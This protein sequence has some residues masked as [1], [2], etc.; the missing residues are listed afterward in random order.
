MND[1]IQKIAEEFRLKKYQ[2]E[3]TL[4]LLKEE[5]T[6]PF[7]AHYRQDRTGGLDDGRIRAIRERWRYLDELEQRRALAINTIAAAGQMTPELKTK[8]ENTPSRVELEDVFMP[9]RSRRRV[10][11][12]AARQKGLD[13]LADLIWQQVKPETIT[14]GGL[15]AGASSQGSTAGNVKPEEGNPKPETPAPSTEPASQKPELVSQSVE[16]AAQQPEAATRSTE[17]DAQKPEPAVQSADAAAQQPEAATQSTESAAQNPEPAAQSADAAAQQPEAATQSTES[18]AQNPEPAAQSTGAAAQQ[19]EAATQSTPDDAPKKEGP[20]QEQIE[21]RKSKIEN[22]LPPCSPAEALV[23][24]FINAEK[25][26]KDMA[27]AL[28][29]ARDIVA[30]RIAENAAFRKIA[31]ELL[32]R[33]GKFATK[34]RDGVDLAKGKYASFA[35]VSEPLSKVYAHRFLQALRG[36]SE[37]Q[38]MVALE[39]P[40]ERILAELKAQILTNPGAVL[41]PELAL[42]IEEAYDRLLAPALDHELRQEMKHRADSEIIAVCARNFHSMLLQP[43]L[44]RKAVLAVDP[45]PGQ[46]LRIA[47]LDPA[48]KVLAHAI[49]SPEKGEDERKTAAQTLAKHIREHQVQ[50]V[51]IGDGAG[52][53]EAD[54]FV[55]GVLSVEEFKEVFSVVVHLHGLAQAGREETDVEMPARGAAALGRYLQ[56]PFAELAKQSPANLSLG[57]HQH[58]VDQGMLKQNLEEVLEACANGIGADA[59]TAGVSI[60]R[61]VSGLNT[62][63]AE[64]LVATRDT[65]GGFKSREDLRE[66][67]GATPKTFEQ[68]AGF[69]RVPASSNPLDATAIHPE[70]YVVVEAMAASLNAAVK[71]LLGSAELVGKLEWAKF[72]NEQCGEYLL[73]N[74]VAALKEPG[75][76]VRG[77]FTRP[78]FSPEVREISDLKE[79]MILNGVVTNLTAFGAFLDI[80]VHQEG[81]VHVS[82]I[83]RKFIRDASEA[84]SVGQRVKVKVLSVDTERKRISLSMKELEPPPPPRAERKPERSTQSGPREGRKERTAGRPARAPRPPRAAVQAAPASETRA[85]SA[86]SGQGAAATPLTLPSPLGG[87][88]GVRGPAASLAVATTPVAQAVQRV[89]ASVP[90][91]GTAAS[92]A[93]S[94]GGDSRAPR[95]FRDRREGGGPRAP[96]QPGKPGE[97]RDRHGP[98]K[99]VEPGKPD[100]SK[101]FVRGKRKER[102]RERG[103]GRG[104]EGASREEV[105][106]VLRSQEGGGKT[107]G[108]LLR[109]AGV[110]TEEKKD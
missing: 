102:E 76:D 40:R 69:L 10:R 74:L 62:Q 8:L 94:P 85:S 61:H 37:K 89:A 59:N 35:Q 32:H 105:R 93:G 107:L 2:V 110:S 27:E 30:E 29:G 19:P 9:Y 26:V 42:G 82:A 28:A 34:A 77:T 56:D 100:Y 104:P 31:R 91:E 7:I 44:G 33:E 83:T 15:V 68:C 18:A 5:A 13:G 22:S 55:R 92:A 73:K 98:A 43:P 80:G 39:A 50:A 12:S 1:L 87:E 46:G 72:R 41:S 101:F 53:R 60:L 79:G 52:S 64:A 6:V 96:G 71:D 90:S 4:T 65:K 106:Q 108:D 57:Q 16:A 17:S 84:L 38:L 48:G 36:A 23:R 24:P 75:R 11:S 97:R 20:V 66:I 63:L 67:P 51:A 78:E 25:G 3:A 86:T 109:K 99:P 95:R 14:A 88:G 103:P 45:T 54:Q 47:V 21:N 81:L 58:D 70:S 49:V